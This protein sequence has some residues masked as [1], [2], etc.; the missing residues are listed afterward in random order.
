MLLETHWT[1]NLIS[2]L[3]TLIGHY[4]KFEKQWHLAM[5]F[6][7]NP[8]LR[9]CLEELKRLRMAIMYGKYNKELMK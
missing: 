7:L 4:S 6:G 9:D 1:V 8:W 5:L 2:Q 3:A